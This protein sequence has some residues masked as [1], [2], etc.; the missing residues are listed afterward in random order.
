MKLIEEDRKDGP[1]LL[2]FRS[3]G[4]LLYSLGAQ[5]AKAPFI[6]NLDR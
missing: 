6:S 2:S 5:M 1:E 4:G 3:R